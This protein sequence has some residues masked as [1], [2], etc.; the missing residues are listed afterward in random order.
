MV[1]DNEKASSIIGSG[2]NKL[3]VLVMPFSLAL[4]ISQKLASDER[5]CY[6]LVVDVV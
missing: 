2:Y 3:E 6:G 5:T 1:P 4:G